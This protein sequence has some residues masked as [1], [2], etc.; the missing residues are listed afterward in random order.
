MI[1]R[2][3][4]TPLWHSRSGPLSSNFTKSQC[5]SWSLHQPPNLLQFQKCLL[6]YSP[7]ITSPH[8]PPH[9]L[10]AHHRPLTQTEAVAALAEYSVSS[11]GPSLLSFPSLT[12]VTAQTSNQQPVALGMEPRCIACRWMERNHCSLLTTLE[13]GFPSMVWLFS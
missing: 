3:A 12:S 6:R 10:L 13:F 5:Y 2:S 9:T 8:Q 11:V 7:R 1:R 4:L